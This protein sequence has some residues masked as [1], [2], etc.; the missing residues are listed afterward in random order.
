MEQDH[1]IELRLRWKHTWDDKEN[2]FVA[3][4]DGYAGS[5]GRIYRHDSGGYLKGN[6]FWAMNAHGPE[7]S[8]N[9]EPL[10]GFEPTPRKAAREVEKAWFAAIRGSS[11]DMPPPVKNGYLAA[12]EGE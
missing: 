7:I 10:F 6:W 8:R 9:I 3:E 12:K 2:D 5:V 4:V 11:L 1:E